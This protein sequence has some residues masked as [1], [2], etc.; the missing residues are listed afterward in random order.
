MYLLHVHRETARGRSSEGPTRSNP[1]C[2]CARTLACSSRIRSGTTCA[3]RKNR[4]PIL[5]APNVFLSVPCAA[6]N[7]AP[8]CL[9]LSIKH[10][11]HRF[12]KDG[13]VLRDDCW[14]G[15]LLLSKT[16]VVFV[17]WYFLSLATRGTGRKLKIIIITAI[18]VPHDAPQ[19]CVC[20]KIVFT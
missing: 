6:I 17:V 15:E 4:D 12:G 14:W 2:V 20:I 13:E 9:C 8:L 10:P 3:E 16:R 7:S 5:S 11:P 19:S 1:K 18:I